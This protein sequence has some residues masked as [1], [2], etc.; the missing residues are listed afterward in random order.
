MQ[1]STQ[2]PAA[3][4]SAQRDPRVPTLP[5][6]PRRAAYQR[7]SALADRIVDRLA[8]VP[9]AIEQKREFGGDTYG[10]RLHFGASLEDGRAVLEIAELADATVVQEPAN[11]S[12]LSGVFIET[13]AVVE[14]V[15]VVARAL[16]STDDA[17]RLRGDEAPAE[18][19][20]TAPEEGPPAQAVPLG[21]SVIA[22]SPILL[23]A[24]GG[25]A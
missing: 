14:G 6:D 22:V 7:A 10:I 4:P 13:R 18:E 8:V 11:P 17:A 16:L 25:D 3:A 15:N 1:E 2:T 12:G 20:I 5:V 19:P 21:A 24:A 9:S 23:L